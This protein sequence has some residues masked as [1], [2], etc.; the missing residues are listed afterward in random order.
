MSET[1]KLIRCGD[2]GFLPW[3]IVCVHVVEG[4]ATEV[5]A[6]PRED[7]NETEYDWLCRQ[8]YE[9][10]DEEDD[11]E[12]LLVACIHCLREFIEPY[13]VNMDDLEPYRHYTRR[14]ARND[15]GTP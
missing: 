3:G 14:P 2:H 6:V 13:R 5:V 12:D 9:H 10:L 11:D 7:G 1:P 4:T 8:C 15:D